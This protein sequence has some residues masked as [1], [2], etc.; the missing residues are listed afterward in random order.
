MLILRVLIFK[1]EM[2]VFFVCMEV[3]IMIVKINR[4][5][6]F[7]VAIKELINSVHDFENLNL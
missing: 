4:K 2:V 5:N 1:M 6:I 3:M 7:L